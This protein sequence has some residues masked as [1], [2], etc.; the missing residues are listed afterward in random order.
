MVELRFSFASARRLSEHCYLLALANK[1]AQGLDFS[2][3]EWM[4]HGQEIM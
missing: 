1:Q 2:L 4:K 3:C